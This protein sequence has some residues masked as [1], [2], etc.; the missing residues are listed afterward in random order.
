MWPFGKRKIEVFVRHCI[1]SSV[2][3]H[4]KRY[5]Q[6]SREACYRNLLQTIDLKKANLTFFLDGQK[7][8]HFLREENRFPVIEIQAGT[9]SSSF[10]QL[11]DLVE[12]RRF[13]PETILYFLEDDYLHRP[14]WVEVLL[15]GFE[16][17]GVE[18]ATLYDHKDKYFHPSYVELKSQ[19]FQ[20][21]SCH[22]RSTPSTTNT[23]AVRAKTLLEHLPIHRQ[24]SEER[25][26]TADHEKFQKLNALLISS[27]PG[28]STHCE[29]EFASPC[30]N[31]ENEFMELSCL[32][33]HSI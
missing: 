32:A 3:Q 28:F 14:N 22:W 11:L 27:I 12:K 4:K 29:P 25:K 21:K 2:S 16:I 31:W 10:L 5:P 17:P 24:F 1:F 23:F 20:T 7:K 26:I 18:Y 13:H 19:L 33:K 8:D 30:Y 9:E 6:F 15:E